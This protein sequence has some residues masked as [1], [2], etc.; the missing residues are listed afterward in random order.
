[1]AEPTSPGGGEGADL[2]GRVSARIE[3]IVRAAE[4]EAAVVQRDI[5][6]QRQAAHTE[7]RRY[8]IE[9]KRQAD[10]LVEQRVGALRS[11]T[12]DLI[13]RA[14]TARRELDSLITALERGGA[15]VARDLEAAPDPEPMRVPEPPRAREPEPAYEDEL[16]SEPDESR[17][18]PELDAEPDPEPES[19]P[20]R[21]PKL[22]PRV[23]P[24][25]GRRPDRSP[26]QAVEEGAPVTGPRRRRRRPS[27][28]SRSQSFDAARLVAIEMAVAGRTRA[29]VD[30][31]LRES[32]R[33]DDTA[34]LL[35]D[36][37]GGD[38]S[39]SSWGGSSPA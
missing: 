26:V 30:R 35:D 17:S 15:G 39:R 34:E 7:A 18:E 3:E 31:H 38:A 25:S 32:F 4:R 9:S 19:R 8:L 28:E 20:R 21:R 6:A 11:L 12:D 1:M 16:D 29:E 24:G 2:T 5:D 22:P 37:F 14:E 13:D 36:V 10:A 27:A 23:V 33:I